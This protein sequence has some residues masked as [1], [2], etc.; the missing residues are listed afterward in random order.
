M[1]VYGMILIIELPRLNSIMDTIIVVTVLI[2]PYL[3]IIP[4][5]YTALG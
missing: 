3:L 5:Y 2:I 1:V 4:Y